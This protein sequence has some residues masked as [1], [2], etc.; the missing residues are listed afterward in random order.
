MIWFFFPLHSIV[1]LVYKSTRTCISIASGRHARF[2][3]GGVSR[4]VGLTE[5][6]R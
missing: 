2:R 4:F 5:L 3:G 6:F 1:I